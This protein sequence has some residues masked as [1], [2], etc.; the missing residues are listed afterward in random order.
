MTMPI[1]SGWVVNVMR[2]LASVFS[3]SFCFIEKIGCTN[4]PSLSENLKH[5]R[6]KIVVLLVQ[7]K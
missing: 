2:N 7:W 4:G 5:S 1:C 3:G 6:R